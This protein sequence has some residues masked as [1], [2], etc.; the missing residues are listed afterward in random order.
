MCVC[1]CVCEH[2]VSALNTFSLV[3][4]W[5]GIFFEFRTA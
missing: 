5:S 4:S 3:W 1:V 2:L